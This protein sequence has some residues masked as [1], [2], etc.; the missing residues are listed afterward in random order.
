MKQRPSAMTSAPVTFDAAQLASLS[1][2][3]NLIDAIAAALVCPPVCPERTVHGVDVADG[4]Q[5]SL[6]LMPAWTTGEL[7]G[8]KLVTVF[9]G[10]ADIGLPALHGL[11]LLAC[12]RTGIPLA[13]MDAAELTTRRTAA[14]SALAARM[15]AR[16][17]SRR[18]LVMGTGRLAPRLAEAHATVRPLT[19]I[20]VWGRNPSRAASLAEE[21]AERLAIE[22]TPVTDLPA[23]IAAADIISTAT[24]AREPILEGK[25]LAPG[26]H[27]D[28]VGSFRA[29][30]READDEVICRSRVFV[31]ERRAALHEAGDLLSP[32]ARGRI[33]PAHI[34]GELVDLCEG[35]LTGRIDGSCITVFKSVGV[36]LEDLACATLAWSTHQQREATHHPA[37][38]H[39]RNSDE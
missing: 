11:Y 32:M 24:T 7:L 19:R 29:D 17:E 18:L 4:V 10:N 28:L 3:A 30:M 38:S 8:V 34:L 12:A 13:L 6:L 27:V 36:A 33:T 9:P 15:L 20:D 26:T 21:I 14:A 23:S 2:M 35:R 25:Y 1:P 16:P 39:R 31:D 5:A 37:R 22:A